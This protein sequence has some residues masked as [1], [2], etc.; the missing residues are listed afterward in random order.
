MDHR[1]VNFGKWLFPLT[2]CST[3]LKIH[4]ASNIAKKNTNM[5]PI[6]KKKG[7][8]EKSDIWSSNT[9]AIKSTIPRRSIIFISEVGTSRNQLRDL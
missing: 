7:L 6:D 4:P 2:L 5:I 3:T 9:F 1:P 8:Y